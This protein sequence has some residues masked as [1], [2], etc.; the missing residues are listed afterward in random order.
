[1]PASLNARGIRR[2]HGATVIL[3]TIDLLVAPGDHIGLVGANGAGKT[4]LLRVLAGIDAPDRG[5]VRRTP[6][7]A[8]VGYLPQEATRSTET[9]SDFLRRRTGVADA[10][11]ALEQTGAAL[12]TGGDPDLY[13]HALERYLALGGPDLAARTG[14]VCDDL[15]L[16]IGTL[17]QEMH[18][19]SGGQAARVSLASLLLSRYDVFL[20]D[21]PTNDLDLDGLDR[22]EA[23]VCSLDA[24]L[25]VVSH[26]RAFLERTVTSVFELDEVTHTATLYNGGWLTYLDARDVARRHAEEAFGEYRDQKRELTER[27][28]AQRQWASVGA[29]K[30]K[31]S[32]K[33][34]DKAQRDFALN[35]TEKQASKVR[36][37]E[38]AL[39]RL[40]VVEKPFERWRLS[41]T[42]AS[43]ARSGDVVVRLDGAVL[44]RGAFVLGPI[45]LEI[46]WGDRVGILGAN[47]SGKTTL[48]D[49]IL[50]RLALREGTRWFG[51][52]VVVGELDQRRQRFAGERPLLDAF[53]AEADAL[54]RPARSLLAKFGLGA[55]HV[56]RPA[57]T[58]SPGERTRAELALLMARGV[59][60]LVLD[61]PTNHLD[62]PAIEQLE[63]A[64]GAWDGTLLLVTHD[65]RLL[66]AV[67]LTRTIQL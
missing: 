34:H 67:D 62:L 25:V 57:A 45:D 31:R 44:E 21:E 53:S 10:E 20:L 30:L 66:D 26:D 50:G 35:R 6:P 23:W 46:A 28:R 43:T 38:K 18:S 39:E 15:S 24:G 5:S 48:L 59:N 64:L 36:I 65:R 32:P 56:S 3:D 49:A 63:L 4:T 54:P 37:T 1:M 11:R 61:E 33:D 52:G 16:P 9:A 12:A 22:I 47:G 19:L 51:P 55:D 58:L 41:F 7:A 14:A 13:S 42:I 8:T 2:A 60:C 27:A 40:D 17:D 29:K